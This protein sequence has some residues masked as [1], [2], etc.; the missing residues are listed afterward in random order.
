MDGRRSGKPT[1]TEGS[2][3]A[4]TPRGMPGDLIL[5]SRWLGTGATTY[6]LPVQSSHLSSVRDHRAMPAIFRHRAPR[7]CSAGCSSLSSR[8]RRTRWSCRALLHH[9]ALSR[10]TF[11]SN[12]PAAVAVASGTPG[13]GNVTTGLPFS[14]DT[15]VWPTTATVRVVSAWLAPSHHFSVVPASGLGCALGLAPNSTSCLNGSPGIG[16]VFP[17]VPSICAPGVSSFQA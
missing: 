13:I 16:T 12:A 2:A 10:I 3:L 5:P 11:A 6:T 1:A 8:R 14:H 9:D 4:I 7:S 17:F 15:D